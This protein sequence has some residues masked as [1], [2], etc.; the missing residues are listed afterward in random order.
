MR[1]Q[2]RADTQQMAGQTAKALVQQMATAVRKLEYFAHHLGW[3]WL[4]GNELAFDDAAAVAMNTLPKG[5]LVQVAVADAKAKCAIPGSVTTT[6][7]LTRNHRFSLPTAN[8]SWCTPMLA[9]HDFLS[10]HR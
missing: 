2:V 9:S 8:T 3:L 10:V 5:A 6:P 7:L 4:K 1:D